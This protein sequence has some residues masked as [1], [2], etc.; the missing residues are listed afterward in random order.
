MFSRLLLNASFGFTLN[1]L[2]FLSWFKKYSQLVNLGA[3]VS[4]TLL[5]CGFLKKNKKN[6]F[7]KTNISSNIVTVIGS[8]LKR[9]NKVWGIHNTKR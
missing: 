2:Q 9:V 7:I 5:A 4:E 6:N 8:Q 1:K 3:L